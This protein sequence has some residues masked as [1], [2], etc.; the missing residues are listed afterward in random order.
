V[1]ALVDSALAKPRLGLPSGA[2][3]RVAAPLRAFVT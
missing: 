3:A 2:P 1:L